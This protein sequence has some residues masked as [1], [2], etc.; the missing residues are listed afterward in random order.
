MEISTIFFRF[1][2]VFILSS[3]FG[4]ERQKSHKPIGFGTF[5]FVSVGACGLAIS[6]ILL[7]DNPL[8]IIGAI[9]TGIGFLGA[10][11]LIRTTDKIFGFTTAASIWIFSIIGLTIGIGQYLIGSIMYLL[12]WGV[13]LIDK[14]LE[15]RGVGTYQKKLVIIAN[16]NIRTEDLT[17][18]LKIDSRKIVNIDINKKS[19][20]YTITMLLE[21][22][23][24]DINEIPKKLF[25]AEW[26]ESFK[27]E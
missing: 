8:P 22:T 12:V 2:I 27:L 24:E 18:M 1:L 17:S 16:K 21:G 25:K 7:N 14:N 11:A 6:A 10:G 15:R 3:I 26:I 20:Q 4:L 5:I 9:I 13:I 19:N 23:K